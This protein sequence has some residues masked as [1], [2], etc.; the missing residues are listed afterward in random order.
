[1]NF[2]SRWIAGAALAL[3]AA[4]ALG[5]PDLA[6]LREQVMATER[7]FAKTMAERDLKAFAGHVSETTV[8]W[9]GP[10]PL[11]GRDAVVAFWKRFYDQPEAPFAWEPDEVEVLDDGMLAHSSGPVRD[12]QGKVFARFHTVW[13]QEAPGVWRVVFDRGERVCDCAAKP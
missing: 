7:A 3:P 1:M 6:A 10:K 9:S 11:H 12:P 5:A 2:M 8:W 4:W 13:R